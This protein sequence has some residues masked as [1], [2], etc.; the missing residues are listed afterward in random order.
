VAHAP[1]LQAASVQTARTSQPNLFTTQQLGN[2]NLFAE[3]LF[4]K[5]GKLSTA[6]SALW[7]ATAAQVTPTVPSVIRIPT[8]EAL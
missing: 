1:A 8:Q 2:A 4:M 6:L 7:D 5:I 3:E